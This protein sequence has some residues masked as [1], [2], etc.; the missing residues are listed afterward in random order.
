MP[1]TAARAAANPSEAAKPRKLPEA[2]EF[3]PGQISVRALL[4]TVQRHEGNTEA[5]VEAIRAQFFAGSAQKQADP[6]RR[7]QQQRTR[8]YNA[9]LGASKY[10]LVTSSLTALTDL[11]AE[12]LASREDE[13]LH[14]LL[15]R[16]IIRDLG[17][18]EVLVALR[19]MKSAGLTIDKNSLAGYLRQQGFE[20][21]RATTHHT[22]LLQWAARG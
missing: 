3:S 2:N 12:A 11:G 19:E 13:E 5:I 15:A 9:L 10:G 16:H 1:P 21:P 4:E 17:G 20:L 8:A 14:R 6:T 18:F 22:K 7:L